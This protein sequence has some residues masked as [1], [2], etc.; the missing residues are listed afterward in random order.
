MTKQDALAKYLGIE[1]VDVEETR[2][3]NVFD[4]DGSEYLVLTDGEAYEKARESILES[5]WAFNPDFLAA[6]A[7]EGIDADVIKAIQAND[8]CEGN[9]KALTALIQDVDHF[10]NDAISSDGRGHFL[11]TYDGEENW[12]SDF[13]IYMMN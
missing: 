6:H 4:A 9:N 7:R 11:N 5:V 10:V 13:F 1:A 8:R 3:E 12:E 2:A